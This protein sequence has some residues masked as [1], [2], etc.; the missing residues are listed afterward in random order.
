MSIQALLLILVFGAI[1]GGGLA[2]L[3]QRG[4]DAGVKQAEK[5]S[6][7]LSTENLRTILAGR[8]WIPETLNS[9]YAWKCRPWCRNPSAK[10]FV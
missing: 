1:I 5:G 4:F 8:K 7:R 10:T 6:I 9:G 2:F 3:Y